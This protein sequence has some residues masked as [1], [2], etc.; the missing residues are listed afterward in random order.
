MS[1]SNR[2]VGYHH[3]VDEI[4]ATNGDDHHVIRSILNKKGINTAYK[5]RALLRQRDTI[6]E[7]LYDEYGDDGEITTSNKPLRDCEES[8][9]LYE[10]MAL[11]SFLHFKQNQLGPK[12]IF[13]LEISDLTSIGRP[14][15]ASSC[16]RVHE[17]V[18]ITQVPY[19]ITTAHYKYTPLRT[20]FSAYFNLG[21]VIAYVD[22]L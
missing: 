1:S 15:Y 17:A 22:L 7:L 20:F 11:E 4:L 3:L 9:H 16:T 6:A 2:P 12:E 8:S 10:L 21:D 13:R 19:M 14:D 18:V 5:L